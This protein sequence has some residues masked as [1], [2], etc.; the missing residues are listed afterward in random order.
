MNRRYIASFGIA[1]PLA[2]L[3]TIESAGMNTYLATTEDTNIKA[4]TTDQ[5]IKLENSFMKTFRMSV[6]F[7]QLCKQTGL[8][9]ERPYKFYALKQYISYIMQ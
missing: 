1:D 6:I 3:L 7:H 9:I 8:E 2:I 4:K 5:N